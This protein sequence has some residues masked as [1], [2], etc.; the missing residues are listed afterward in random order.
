[1]E[2]QCPKCNSE[3]IRSGKLKRHCESCSSDFKLHIAC[4]S[5]G[6]EI[7]RLVACGSVSFWCNN[8][9]ELKSKST[10]VY[11]LKND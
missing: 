1:M 8:C 4:N 3:L 11:T 9:N 10:A 5:C 7:E 6:E 2:L